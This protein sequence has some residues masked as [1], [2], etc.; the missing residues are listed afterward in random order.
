[1]AAT[2]AI[3]IIRSLISLLLGGAHLYFVILCFGFV[4]SINPLPDWLLSTPALQGSALLMLSIA[5]L[6]LH[7]LLA[8]PAVVAMLYLH[9]QLRR[10][11]LALL[12][13]PILAFALNSLWQL[14]TVRHELSVTYLSYINTLVPVFAL[15]LIGMLAL[16][17]FGH[18]KAQQP[19]DLF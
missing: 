10:Y 13:L 19:T 15:V 9:A 6:L 16:K 5:D 8:I 4:S 18:I 3:F 1:M 7:V 12:T 11:H 2:L 14:F 17:Y